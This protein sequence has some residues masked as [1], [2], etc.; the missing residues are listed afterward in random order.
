MTKSNFVQNEF[1][2]SQ[3]KYGEE[4][5]IVH[6]GISP[7]PTNGAIMT[8]IHLS[9]NFKMNRIGEDKGYD[10]SRT[11]NP[12]RSVLQKHLA[13]LEHGHYCTTHATGMASATAVA[14]ILNPGDHIIISED[15]YGGVFRLFSEIVA[16]RGVE[17]SFLDLR[18][19]DLV[20]NSI[21][22]NTRC[23]WAESPTNPLLRLVDIAGL[24]DISNANSIWLLVDNTFASPIL[25]KPLDL[26]A[27]IV[28]HSLTKYING[29]SDVL[30]GAVITRDTNLAERID[31]VTNA[32]GIGSSPFDSWMILRGSKT[33]KVRYLQQ[34]RTAIKVAKFLEGHEKVE[35]V[36]FPG[37]P[38]HPDYDL[39]ARQQSG[40]GA[41]I[42]FEVTGGK[43]GA[44]QT[45]ENVELCTLAESL[46]CV[47]TLIEVPAF[48]SHA[49]MTI[50][51]R[52]QAGINDGLIRLSIGLESVEDIIQDLNT[53][54]GKIQVTK[55]QI[56]HEFA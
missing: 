47:A 7:D 35:R 54:L 42:G 9:S 18:N 2:K 53:A 23:I 3:N 37:L 20:Q 19:L 28:L 31:Y 44:F 41:M 50:E 27:H 12:T 32:L 10:Y 4:T 51:A 43:Q 46:G 26:G 14:H 39:A 15:C 55:K 38:S 49:S 21:K 48:Q 16:P 56:Q 1:T 13:Q 11:G 33:L 36:I 8:P 45:V 22:E 52:L 6:G 25:Q 29:H 17:V 24:A 5:I 40:P 34:Q 30:G